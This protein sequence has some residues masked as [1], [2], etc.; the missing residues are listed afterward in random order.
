MLPPGMSRAREELRLPS[1]GET[2][3]AWRW[4][5]AGDGPH[6]CVLLAHGFAGIRE[7]RLPAYAERFAAAGLA[8]V[9]F[10]YRHFGASS[11]RPRQL[12]EVGRQL[13]DWHAALA[14]VRA[15]P[16]ID[17][18]RVGLWGTALSGGHVV[19]VAASDGRIAAVVA[20]VPHAD[21]LATSR[22]QG[23]AA[24]ARLLPAVSRDLFHAALGRQPHRIRVVGPP[25]S[26]AAMTSRD[27]EPGY[28]ALIPPGVDWD[29]TVAARGV[30][31]AARYRPLRSAPRVDCPLL[32]VVARR[33]A[34]TPPDA[35]R[36]MAEQAPR[37]EWTSLDAGHFD[38]YLGEAFEQAVAWQC[39]FLA[40]WLRP[41]GSPA[42]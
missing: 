11:G 18:D 35:G 28:R 42:S 17:P 6:P 13:E 38:V 5:P 16:E 19:E 34:L 33:D 4:V 29:D 30:L 36:R 15:M 9:V 27:A 10:D 31:E 20:Q 40:R 37:G 32:V 39:E 8:A 7:A 3:A 24:A 22:A 21:G 41:A 14:A 26:V 2:L 23:G 1:Q 25:G 12:L